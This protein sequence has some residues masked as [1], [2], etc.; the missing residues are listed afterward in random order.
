M[1]NNTAKTIKIISKILNISLISLIVILAILLGGTRLIGLTPYTVLSGSM[2]PTY[3][4]GSVV[5]VSKID[6]NKLAVGDAITYRISGGTVVTHQ[7]VEIIKDNGLSFR[8]KGTAN[9]IVDGTPVPSTAV[10]GKVRFSVPYLGYVSSF[11]QQPMGLIAIVG[12]CLA[13]FIFSG[14]IESVFKE[15]VNDEPYQ[16]A[17]NA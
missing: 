5:Y 13:V 10:I 6:P 12:C 3:H 4:V 15:P 16:D 2:E 11:V 1:V 9:N 14:I 7:I 17:T 8:T